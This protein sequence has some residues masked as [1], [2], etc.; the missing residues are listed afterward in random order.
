MQQQAS[1]RRSHAVQ[2]YAFWNVHEPVA[3]E[4][5]WSGG[6]NL[7]AFIEVSACDGAAAAAVRTYSTQ[8]TYRTDETLPCIGRACASQ[9]CADAGLFVM[10][11]IGCV[12]RAVSLLCGAHADTGCC[13]R[14]A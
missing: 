6:A 11:R 12:S 7:T 1:L 5:V 8:P 10:L 4:L 13:S 3:G 14:H 2:T 9:V